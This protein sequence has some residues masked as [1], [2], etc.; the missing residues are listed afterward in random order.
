M[1]A[2]LAFARRALRDAAEAAQPH[3]NTLQIRRERA[4]IDAL[5]K[6]GAEQDY[7]HSAGGVTGTPEGVA[8]YYWFDKSLPLATRQAMAERLAFWC[9]KAQVD[10]GKPMPHQIN[11]N[12]GVLGAFSNSQ[13]AFWAAKMFE[14]HYRR[15]GQRQWLTRAVEIADWLIANM[16]VGTTP[17]RGF[18]RR[19]DQNW[20]SIKTV[21][22]ADVLVSLAQHT[23]DDSYT[24]AFDEHLAWIDEHN[25]ILPAI[26]TPWYYTQTDATTPSTTGNEDNWHCNQEMIGGLLDAY[27]RSGDTA[28]FDLAERMHDG[29]LAAVM[30]L[31]T[32]QHSGNMNAFQ[33]AFSSRRLGRAGIGTRSHAIA[34]SRRRADGGFGAPAPTNPSNIFPHTYLLGALHYDSPVEDAGAIVPETT[35]ITRANLRFGGRRDFV[36]RALSLTLGTEDTDAAYTA[37]GLQVLTADATASLTAVDAGF[38]FNNF[39]FAFTI[40]LAQNADGTARNVFRVHHADTNHDVYVYMTTNTFVARVR[41]TGSVH[42]TASVVMVGELFLEGDTL[43][44]VGRIAPGEPLRVGITK[45]NR[46][47]TGYS[48]SLVDVGAV[49]GD[50]A[51]AVGK[52]GSIPAMLG[53]VSEFAVWSPAP[54]TFAWS[55]FV[56]GMRDRA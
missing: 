10:L 7:A 56:R 42:A 19:S 15:T 52:I 29:L 16:F 41:K 30:P 1:S 48:Q 14:D 8:M 17:T 11:F 24:E 38:D 20:I 26:G 13:H 18:L 21:S 36:G 55:E 2:G 12:T 54:E 25:E 33:T 51:V 40:R 22:S 35:A 31:I 43:T 37:G 46:E 50:V 3:Q 34:I 39:A 27:D 32:H 53:T 44:C 9:D 6:V 28:Y 47:V 45:G 49:T 5:Y 23:G 4:R